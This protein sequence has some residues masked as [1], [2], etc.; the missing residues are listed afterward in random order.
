MVHADVRRILLKQ[1][2]APKVLSV[3]LWRRA[4][5]QYTIGHGARLATL[6]QELQHWPGLFACSNYEG[7][8]AL[9]DCV[10]HGWEQADAIEQFLG[11]RV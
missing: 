4:I 5:P 1:D 6:H 9:G 2:V 3:K 10:R 8:V 7:G 11:S